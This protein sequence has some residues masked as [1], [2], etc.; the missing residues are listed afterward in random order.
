[1]TRYAE[2]TSVPS[3]RSRAEIEKTLQRYGAEGFMYGWEGTQAIIGFRA[4]GRMIRFI[5][6]MPDRQAATFWRTP[7]RGR[8]RSA[9]Q[10][11][12]AYE[13]AVRQCW[14]ALALA[15]K[16]KL[17]AVAAGITTFNDEFLAHTM[18]PDGSTVGAW[19]APQLDE[20]YARGVMPQF[21]PAL[22]PGK[23]SQ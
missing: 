13:Q 5:L 22:P 3:D 2:N 18:L 4:H 11:E 21:L 8:L 7:G 20:V 19:A 9:A 16:A 12:E 23:V 6:P 14:R 17:E 10:A 1:M 15:I